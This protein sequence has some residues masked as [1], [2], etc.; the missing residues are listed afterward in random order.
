MWLLF[1]SDTHGKLGIINES[2]AQ[3]RVDAVIHTGDFSFF[4][5]GSFE[6]RS[7]GELRLHV[8]H[9]DLPRTER[10]RILALSRKGMIRIAGEHLVVFHNHLTF[11]FLII[12]D[13]WSA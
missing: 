4:D 10:D 5:N 2:V 6:R 8:V 7:D 11:F 1:I 3:V 9:S 13:D 12:L